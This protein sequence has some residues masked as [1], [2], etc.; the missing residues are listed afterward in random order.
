ML[1]LYSAVTL[2]IGMRILLYSAVILQY[3]AVM[4]RIG[5]G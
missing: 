1:S 4:L 5:L 2:R 3:G